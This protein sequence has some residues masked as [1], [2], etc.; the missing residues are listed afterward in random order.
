MSKE[1]EEF[2]EQPPA[3]IAV[4]EAPP[5]APTFKHSLGTIHE[6]GIQWRTFTGWDEERSRSIPVIAP[7][8]PGV[9]VKTLTAIKQDNKWFWEF[10]WV[11]KKSDKVDSLHRSYNP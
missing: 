8:Q 1:L 7:Y 5:L 3:W 4:I 10:E 9:S 11:T 6:T 2:L